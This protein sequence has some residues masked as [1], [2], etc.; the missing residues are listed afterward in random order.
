MSPD[1]P[2][3]IAARDR[4]LAISADPDLSREA[5][6]FALC[7]LAYLVDPQR[8]NGDRQ[9][10]WTQAVGEMMDPPDSNVRRVYRPSQV[11]RAVIADDI[12]RYEIPYSRGRCPVPKTRGKNAGKPCGRYPAHHWIDRDPQTGEATEVGYCRDHYNPQAEQRAQDRVQ[13]W[14]ANGEPVPAANKGGVLARHFNTDWAKLYAWADP[15][16]QPLPDGKAPTPPRP[17][18]TL[19]RGQADVNHAGPGLVDDHRAPALR[20]VGGTGARGWMS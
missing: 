11:V 1:L 10:S 14:K 2:G 17:R 4:M 15:G 7:L 5:K 16:R 8:N 19:I 3:A 18:L 20:A 9:R 13:Q 6:L 12:P